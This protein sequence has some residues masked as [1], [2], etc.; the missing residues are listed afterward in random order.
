MNDRWSKPD[1]SEYEMSGT[2]AVR[3]DIDALF[4]LAVS[5]Y[6][7]REELKKAARRQIDNVL[8]LT[9]L[10]FLLFLSGIFIGEVYLQGKFGGTIIVAFA[11]PAFVCWFFTFNSAH[12]HRLLREK[13]A[14]E[15]EIM[16]DIIYNISGMVSAF[17]EDFR[18]VEHETYRMRLRRLEFAI[19]DKKPTDGAT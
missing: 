3:A 17:R 11:I 4:D 16:R 7:A 8:I 13:S 1:H 5:V 19:S 15:S 2:D 6:S 9:S 10:G 18:P 12:R 14:H